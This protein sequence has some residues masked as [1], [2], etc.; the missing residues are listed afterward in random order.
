MSSFLF[1]KILLKNRISK[2][3]ESSF[4][5]FHHNRQKKFNYF[6]IDLFKDD[7]EYAKNINYFIILIC[8]SLHSSLPVSYLGVS[9]LLFFSH[10]CASLC[11][12]MLTSNSVFVLLS[13]RLLYIFSY[14][15]FFCRCVFI[16]N[17]DAFIE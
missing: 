7:R 14:Q 4:Y 5:P 1:F 16:F 13:P 17:I 10:F 15:F 9:S 6:S 2:Q 3:L 8:L 11:L 12:F